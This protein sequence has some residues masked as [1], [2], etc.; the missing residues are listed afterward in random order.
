MHTLLIS[1]GYTNVI[2]YCE[3]SNIRE[4]FIFANM[5]II[6]ICEVNNSRLGHDKPSSVNDIVNLP[7]RERF[8]FAKLRRCEVS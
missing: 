6:H 1:R 8:I 4:S 5:F 3:F 7:F 2:I